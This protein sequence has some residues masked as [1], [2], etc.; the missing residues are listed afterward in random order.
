MLCAASDSESVAPVAPKE[1]GAA[2]STSA[3]ARTCSTLAT[4]CSGPARSSPPANVA[5][6]ASCSKPLLAE[7][8][9]LKEAFRS[10]YR[11]PN[12]EEAQRRL[13]AFL[14]AADRAQIPSFAACAEGVRQWREELVAYFDQ[15]TT[16]GYAEGVIN[17]VKVIKRR[18][19]GLPT[20]QGF[21]ERVVIA[22]G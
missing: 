6:Y 9:G 13:D 15:P 21:R 7:A 18:A 1:P 11:S 16:N 4:G 5:S 12:R 17:K 14:G 3:G 19:Y 10:I 2:A 8:S 22:R 20:F